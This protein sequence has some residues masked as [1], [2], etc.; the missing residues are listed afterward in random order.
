MTGREGKKHKLAFSLDEI[1]L[2]EKMSSNND[3]FIARQSIRDVGLASL[4]ISV[5]YTCTL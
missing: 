1:L 5:Q 3:D 2:I 4:A